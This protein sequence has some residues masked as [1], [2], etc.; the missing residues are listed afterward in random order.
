MANEFWLSA[1]QWAVLEPLI[2]MN[3]RG[4]KP[5]RNRAVCRFR[6]KASRHSEAMAPSVLI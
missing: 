6:H 1:Q 4:V 3:R 5:R 2:P